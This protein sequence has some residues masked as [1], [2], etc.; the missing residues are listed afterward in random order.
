MMT[1]TK[2]R[3]SCMELFEKFN[4]LPLSREFLL[5]LSFIV[6]NMGTFNSNSDIHSIST[7]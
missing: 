1:G 3:S 6:D 7:R 5:S 4:I 2:G